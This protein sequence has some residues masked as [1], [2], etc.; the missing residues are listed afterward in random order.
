M[1]EKKCIFC[2]K[3]LSKNKIFYED[4]FF[5]AKL[6]EFPGVPG[7]TQVIPKRHV[8]SLFDLTNEEKSHYLFSIENAWG[9]LKKLDLKRKY[10]NMI[11]VNDVSKQFIEKV[12]DNPNINNISKIEQSLQGINDGKDAGQS[13]NHL[14]WHIIPAF[15]DLIIPRGIR[16]AIKDDLDYTK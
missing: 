12:L 1:I 2:Y 7:H 3:N 9:E 10:E 5:Y 16:N 8:G 14:H 13:I 4:E 6:D 11:P 15:P